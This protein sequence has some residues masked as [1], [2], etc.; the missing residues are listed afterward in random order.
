MYMDECLVI[1]KSLRPILLQ[2]PLTGTQGATACPLPSRKSGG[3]VST[4]KWKQ[5]LEP[6]RSVAKS[7]KNIKTLL[8]QNQVGKL[9]VCK[10]NNQEV[11][12]AF[13]GEFQNP[14]ELGKSY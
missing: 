1:A 5:S 13:A 4:A 10:A 3:R 2:S 12:I 7:C 8:T 6:A 11:A 14:T 9:P